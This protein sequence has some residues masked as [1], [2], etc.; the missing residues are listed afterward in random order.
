M[1][2]FVEHVVLCE[3]SFNTKTNL[4][5]YLRIKFFQLHDQTISAHSLCLS[6]PC[7]RVLLHSQDPALNMRV[8]GSTATSVNHE[9]ITPK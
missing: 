2:F 5:H 4:L 1:I 3:Q 6:F 8:H 7:R 9:H